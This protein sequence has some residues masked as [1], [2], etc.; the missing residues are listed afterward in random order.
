VLV[1]ARAVPTCHLPVA[2]VGD[3]AITTLEGLSEDG[4][5]HPVQRA[6]LEMQAAQC[7]ICTSGL[8]ISAVALLARVPHPSD[9]QIGQALDGHLCRCG[10]HVRVQRAVRR[11]AELLSQADEP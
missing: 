5:L 7:G 1:G 6:F 11:A 3:A 8:I 4:E 10:S 2:E 9:A